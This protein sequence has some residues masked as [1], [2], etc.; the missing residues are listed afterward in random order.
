VHVT[1]RAPSLSRS[2]P[3]ICTLPNLLAIA[4]LV[5]TPSLLSHTLPMPHL[6][7]SMASS[8]LQP[9]PHGHPL[10]HPC[11]AFTVRPC[12][13]TYLFLWPHSLPASF[14]SLPSSHTSHSP[15]PH[16]C[17]P[18]CT[19]GCVLGAGWWPNRLELRFGKTDRFGEK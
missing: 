10:R 2:P 18:T 9:C 6:T 17:M 1:C 15:L 4:L 13:N 3:A 8:Y 14:L 5:A 12:A 7:C 11:L 19:L 16:A